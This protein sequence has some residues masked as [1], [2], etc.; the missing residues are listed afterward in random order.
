MNQY[1]ELDLE[2]AICSKDYGSLMSQKLVKKLV[3][4]II[5]KQQSNVKMIAE[6]SYCSYFN[7][8]ERG[9]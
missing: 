6:V 8:L 4:K 3:D 2:A 5:K 7:F 9:R 1:T